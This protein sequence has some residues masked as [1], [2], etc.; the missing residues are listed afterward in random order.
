[1][2]VLQTFNISKKIINVPM[3]NIKSTQTL[4]ALKLKEN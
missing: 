2:V 1:M 3:V 4:K